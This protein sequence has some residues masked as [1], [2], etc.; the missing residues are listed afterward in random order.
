MA[1]YSKTMHP[2]AREPE[3]LS[4]MATIIDKLQSD[5]TPAVSKILDAVFEATLTMINKDF[6]QFPEH[7]TNFYLLLQ[8]YILNTQYIFYLWY[9]YA[10]VSIEI[11]FSGNKQSLFCFIPVYTSSSV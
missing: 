7:R 3:V 2:S 9:K 10:I 11:L 5:I 6:E 4:A 1:D 8:V